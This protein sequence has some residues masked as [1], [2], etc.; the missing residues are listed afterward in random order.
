MTSK[1]AKI[2]A[3]AM[4]LRQIR[5]KYAA[6][7]RTMAKTIADAAKL[8]VEIEAKIDKESIAVAGADYELEHEPSFDTNKSMDQQFENR[9]EITGP[10][11]VDILAY[12]REVAAE[13]GSVADATEAPPLPYE[14]K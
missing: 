8:L 4:Q 12:A 5:F 11:F 1:A 3:Q 10:G 6:T 2:K 7:V 13:A 9:G 14:E